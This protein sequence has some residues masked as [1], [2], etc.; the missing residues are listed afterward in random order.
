MFRRGGHFVQ[1]RS[2]PDC[3]PKDLKK[4][5]QRPYFSPHF[6]SWEIDIMFIRGRPEPGGYRNI[7]RSYLVC[8]NV[9]TKYLVVYPFKGTHDAQQVRDMLEH[10]SK[11]YPVKSIRGDAD[12]TFT[13]K[14]VIK[15]LEQKDINYFFSTS[16]YTHKNSIVNRVIRTLRMWMTRETDFAIDNNMQKRRE[17]NGNKWI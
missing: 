8:I 10:L 9:N 6:H 1:V 11:Q 13:V 15:F 14:I 3:H 4:K 5:F 12:A 2:I 7:L 17:N 16:P